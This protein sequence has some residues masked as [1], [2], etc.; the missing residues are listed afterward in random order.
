M[1]LCLRLSVGIQMA[2]VGG[3]AVTGIHT[4]C[5]QFKWFVMHSHIDYLSTVTI[6]LFLYFTLAHMSLQTPYILLSS[7]L[8]STRSL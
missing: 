1:E 4:K 6:E 3:C 8:E 5:G 2:H 7:S